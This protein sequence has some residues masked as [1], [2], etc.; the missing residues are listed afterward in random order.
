MSESMTYREAGVDI[1]KAD[2]FIK[3]IK[4]MVK[5]TYRTGVIGDIGGFGGFFHLDREKYRHPILV[6]ATDGVGTKLKVAA[7]MNK[8]DTI[9]LD[10]VAMCVN[11]IIVHGATPL[12]FLDYLAMGRLDPEVATQVIKGITDGCLQARCALIGGE[13]AEMPGIYQDPDYDLAGFVVGV[14]EQE[15]LLDGSEI[16]V[17]H[18]LV[19]IASSGLH[20]NG[21]SLV[22]KVLLESGHYSVWD[23]LPELGGPLGQELLK[24]TRIYVETILHLLRDF[25]IAGLAHITGGGLTDNIPRILP[26]S[27]Q[28][29]IYPDQWP[30]PPIFDLIQ[31]QGQIPDSEMRQTFNNGIGMVLVISEE[32]HSEILQ[33]LQAV[34]EQAFVIGEIVARNPE[35]PPLVYL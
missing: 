16:A 23:E 8:H 27:C 31:Q 12:F 19:G 11:D 30:R 20:A 5:S 4:A 32:L 6:S 21:F 18:R 3:G 14:V 13:T 17:G 22:R 26:K 9:G 33:R 24:P 29:V 25:R 35:D 28:A 7:L 2:S 15:R 10:L 34:D 1:D